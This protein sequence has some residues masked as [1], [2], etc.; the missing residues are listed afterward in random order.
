[1]VQPQFRKGEHLRVSVFQQPCQCFIDLLSPGQDLSDGWAAE[2][3]A[4]GPWMAISD[5]FVI[6]VELIVPDRITARIV[7]QVFLQQKSIEEPGGVRQVPFRG[8]GVGHA[9]KHKILRLQRSDQ[10]FTALTH[11]QQGIQQQG[12]GSGSPGP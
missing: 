8:A 10:R 12:S 9:L 5:G 4:L 3:A 6:G 2:H 7:L 11:V 1:M